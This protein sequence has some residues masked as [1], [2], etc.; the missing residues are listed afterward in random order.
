MK[1]FGL[2]GYPL[3]HSFSK[4]YFSEKFKKESLSDHQYINFEIDSIARFPSIF[5]QFE[6]IS[7][8]NCTIPYKQQIIPFLSEVDEVAMQIGA[9]NTIKMI[10]T[11]NGLRLKGFNT[12]SIG[13][14]RTLSPL[15]QKQHKKAIILGTGGAS[16]AVKYVLN[17]LGISF[18]LATRKEELSENEINYKDIDTRFI[19]EHLLIINTTPLGTAPNTDH[20]PDIP[21]EALTNKHLLYDLVYNPEET[22]FMK[23][24]ALKGAKTKNG[25]EMLHEQAI[26]A[27]NI[28]NS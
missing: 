15:L 23:K 26:A 7:G 28:W 9:V 3:G 24:G 13:F 5:D 17:K 16:K 2:I 6:T 14:E 4:K 25:M 20:C 21:Y 27:W 1:T 8:L 10:N 18:V 11:E 19:E 12:D 22:L